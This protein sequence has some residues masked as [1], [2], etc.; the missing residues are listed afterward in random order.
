MPPHPARETHPHRG[1][2]PPKPKQSSWYG[3][4][5]QPAPPGRRRGVMVE[6]PVPSRNLGDLVDDQLQAEH[7]RIELVLGNLVEQTTDA[8]VNAANTR[9]TGGGGVDGAVH[10][11]AG[12]GLK[13]ECLQLPADD[14]G[15]RCPTG[16]VRVTSAGNLPV[17]WV[18]HAVGP[19]YNARY[20]EKARQQLARVHRLALEAAAT[21]ECRSVAF[22]AISTGAYR[23]P[24]AEA[25]PI[26]L[27][28][29]RDFL[30]EPG[31]VEVV[32]FVLFKPAYL[33]AFGLALRALATDSHPL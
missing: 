8:I 3:N 26:A 1:E 23:F 25:A 32:R 13:Q 18:I 12:K 10:R 31:P 17:R 14:Q 22:P 28:A 16:E 30:R 29:A 5:G 33:D 4:L 15:R 9:L 7:G 6:R 24:L 11:A 2:H 21:K 27:Q 20:A 19:F